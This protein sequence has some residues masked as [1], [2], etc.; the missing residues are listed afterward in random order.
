MLHPPSL[1]LSLLC[2]LL[3]EFKAGAEGS[4]AEALQ[5]RGCSTLKTAQKGPR[6]KFPSQ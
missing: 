6:K 2:K 4:L 1:L 5:G 3:P